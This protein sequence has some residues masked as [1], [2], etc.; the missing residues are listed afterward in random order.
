MIGPIPFLITDLTGVRAAAERRTARLA[1]SA[2]QETEVPFRVLDVD[3][4]AAPPSARKAAAMRWPEA[5][6]VFHATM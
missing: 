1:A 6:V 5:G 4:R 3:F 2:M